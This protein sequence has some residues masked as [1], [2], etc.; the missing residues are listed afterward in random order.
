MRVSDMLRRSV[1]A[2][3]PEQTITEAAQIM[4]QAG[5]GALVV[6]DGEVPL[7][8]VTDRDLVRRGLARSMPSDARV[9]ALMTIPV[10]TIDAQADAHDVYE[11]FRSHAI[12]RIPVVRDGRL[13]GMVSVDDV[14]I[15]LSSDL[16]DL[17]RPVTGEVLFPQRDSAP[18]APVSRR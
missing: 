1:V 7:G 9:D 2:V 10:V 18:P 14:L 6:V 16:E 11:V 5:V 12:R 15:H 13:V 3:R 4:D 8:L 17:V